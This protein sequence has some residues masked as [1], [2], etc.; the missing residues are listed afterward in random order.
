MGRS[1]KQSSST[2]AASSSTR[3]NTRGSALS[4]VPHTRDYLFWKHAHGDLDLFASLKGRYKDAW[5]RVRPGLTLMQGIGVEIERL[6]RGFR[7]VLCGQYGREIMELL[8]RSDLSAY[9]AS[10][11]TQDE[12]R[13]TKPDPR[14]FER[15]CER[16]GLESGR[17]IMVGDRMDK[18]VI[19]AKLLGMGTVFVRSGVYKNQK[20]RTPDEL[21]DLT[22][23]GVEGLADA[24]SGRWRGK[25]RPIT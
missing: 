22:L 14:F 24:I 19:P 20:A 1:W 4:L 18:D 9:F 2:R 7:I 21:P 25:L 12:Y 11:A 13:I 8:D 5:G 17:C 6:S 16:E 10:R 3:R 15:I 23:E